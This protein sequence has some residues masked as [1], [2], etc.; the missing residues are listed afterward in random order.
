MFLLRVT[1][2]NPWIA[3]AAFVAIFLAIRVP[4][5]TYPVIQGTETVLCYG[6]VAG[7]IARLGLLSIAV[8]VTLV[9]L[10]AGLPITTN[11][12]AP[13]FG[14]MILVIA[15]VLA[16]CMWAFQTA[17]SGSELWSREAAG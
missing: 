3:G 13:Y 12:S 11:T 10:I 1:L 15:V 4:G 6:L 8:A 14:E 17:T 2:R 16:V 7:V 5:A 9:D